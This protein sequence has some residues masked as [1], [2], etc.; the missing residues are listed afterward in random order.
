[1]NKDDFTPYDLAC[2][3]S[4]HGVFANPNSRVYDDAKSNVQLI[5]KTV[6]LLFAELAKKK[7]DEK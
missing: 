3:I 5:T 1:M 2:F 7:L 6:D 4:L